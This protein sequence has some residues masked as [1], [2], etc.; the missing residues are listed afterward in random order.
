M[1]KYEYKIEFNT[2]AENMPEI[3]RYITDVIKTDLVPYVENIIPTVTVLD[4]NN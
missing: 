2:E 3:L 1:P 4:E